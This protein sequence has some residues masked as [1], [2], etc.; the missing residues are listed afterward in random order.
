VIGS[1]ALVF[2]IGCRKEEATGSTAPVTT[3]SGDLTSVHWSD[4]AEADGHLVVPVSVVDGDAGFAVDVGTSYAFPVV[5]AIVDPA[6]DVVLDGAAWAV[7]DEQ[8]TTAVARQSK[9]TAVQWPVREEDGVLSPGEWQVEVTI[10]DGDGRPQGGEAVEIT[11]MTRKDDDLT[12]ATLHV[13]LVYAEGVDADPERVAAAEQGV[14]VARAA[15]AAAGITL[16]ETWRTSSLDPALGFIG[17]SDPSVE[18]LVSEIAAPGDLVAIFGTQSAY[19]FRGSTPMV[20]VPIDQTGY[21]YSAIAID[22]HDEGRGLDDNARDMVGQTLAHELAHAMGLMHV[23]EIPYFDTY[24][25]LDDTPRR[26]EAF[27]CEDLMAQNLVYPYVNCFADGS[28]GVN[29][30]LTPDQVGVLQRSIA[31]L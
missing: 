9:S 5:D 13:Q 14:E 31:A 23:V 19:G 20:P 10:V 4:V 3:V 28:C 21:R 12:H 15:F 6:G 30:S 7:S 16:A 11:A 29:V 22:A 17:G 26:D 24:D 2:V 18:A 25:A 1:V 8:L 27:A